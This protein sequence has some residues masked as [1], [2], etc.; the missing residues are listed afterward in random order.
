MVVFLDTEFTSLLYPELLSIGLVTLDGRELYVELDL[1]TEVGQARKAAASDFVRHGGVLDLWGLVPGALT[2]ELEMGRR[3]G[4]W[5]PELAAKSPESG[6]IEVAYDYA[7]DFE[8]LE[9]VVRDSGLWDRVQELVVPVN[10]D[11]LTG[12]LDGEPAA[13]ACYSELSKRGLRR[14]H[15]LA[16]AH[17]LRAAYIRVQDTA[18][19]LS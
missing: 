16:D 18:S 2:T 5:L 19:R 3:A 6:R 17:A 9:Y 10:V 11:A 15:A 7:T 4:D 1:S 14:H 8:L 13:E 12:S